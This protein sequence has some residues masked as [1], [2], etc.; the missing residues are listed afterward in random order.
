M[1]YRYT[2]ICLDLHLL[3]SI[4]QDSGGHEV[5]ASLSTP[6]LDTLQLMWNSGGVAA[7]VVPEAKKE[8]DKLK[9][10]GFTMGLL[11]FNGNIYGLPW[12][13]YGLL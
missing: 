1:F 5:V 6:A 11:W 7:L 9:V 8:Q 10:W 13:Y 2:Y 12:V 4:A 3:R